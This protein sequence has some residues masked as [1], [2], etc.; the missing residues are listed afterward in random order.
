VVRRRAGQTEAEVWGRLCEILIE[1]RRQADLSQQELANRIGK[2]QT[3]VSKLE[4]GARRPGLLDVWAICQ[5]TGIR[6]SEVARR[7]ED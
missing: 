1:L 3:F 4:A 5:A 6:L 2:H 7:L